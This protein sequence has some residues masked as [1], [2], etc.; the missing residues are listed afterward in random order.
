MVYHHH[1]DMTSYGPSQLKTLSKAVKGSLY[2]VATTLS[3][4]NILCKAL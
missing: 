3:H 4:L 1:N 2:T